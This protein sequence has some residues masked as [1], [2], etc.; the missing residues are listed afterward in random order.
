VSA[1]PQEL[2]DLAIQAET[3]QR[4]FEAASRV[5]DAADPSNRADEYIARMIA[6]RRSTEAD[7]VFRK[8]LKAYME[9]QR[10][11]A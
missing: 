3:A 5:L 9:S 2:R 10:A 1:F 7:E 11:A 6:C 4:E 8:A